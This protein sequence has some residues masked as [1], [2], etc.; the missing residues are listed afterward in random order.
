MQM[1]NHGLSTGL[2]FFVVGMLYERTHTRDIG[3]MGGL[4]KVTRGSPRRSS[5]RRC[6]RS[7]PA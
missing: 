3:E 7:G 6:P 5:W 2:L 4:A 1:V